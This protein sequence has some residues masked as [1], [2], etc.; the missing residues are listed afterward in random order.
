M[1]KNNN[2]CYIKE[3]FIIAEYLCRYNY[4][5]IVLDYTGRE[6]KSITEYLFRKKQAIFAWLIE[7]N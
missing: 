2:S 4:V 6:K 7:K 1:I 5:F 3:L